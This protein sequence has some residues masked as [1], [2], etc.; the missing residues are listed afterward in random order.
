MFFPNTC[1]SRKESSKQKKMFPPQQNPPQ[2]G[3]PYVQPHPF[4]SSPYDPGMMIPPYRPPRSREEINNWNATGQWVSPLLGACGENPLYWLFACFCPWCASYKQREKLLLG[5]FAHYQC[6][7]GLLGPDCTQNIQSNAVVPVFRGNQKCCLCL[8][9]I[10][11]LSCSV[12]G[13]RWMIQ[14]HYGLENTCCDKLVIN[15]SCP[16]QWLACLGC[17]CAES[18]SDIFFYPVLPCIL[19]QHEVQMA[20]RGYPLEIMPSMK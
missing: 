6:C 3:Y 18:S 2:Q 12:R 10:F 19:T 20:T 8:E 5:N 17:E 14:Q 4:P 16:C 13:N 15:L 7:A 1:E 11:C 9:V